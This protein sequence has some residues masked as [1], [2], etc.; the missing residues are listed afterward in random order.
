KNNLYAFMLCLF[1]IRP[2]KV[3]IPFLK[4]PVREMFFLHFLFVD[5][6]NKRR[7]SKIVPYVILKKDSFKNNKLKASGYFFDLDGIKNFR[8]EK[9]GN[10]I[11][12][13]ETDILKLSLI[14][15]KKPL[16]IN[17]N[18]FINYEKRKSYYYSLT[19][20]EAKGEIKINGKSLDVSGKVWHDH[21]WANEKYAKD[22]W[23]WFSIQ[24]DNNVE[25]MI[26]EYFFES[27]KKK[28]LSIIYPNGKQKFYENFELRH[29]KKIWESKITCMEYPLKW[30]IK[31][32]E[33][34]DLSCSAFLDNQEVLFGSINYWEG[35]IKVK[36][37]FDNK[38]ING[39]GFMELN[40]PFNIKRFFDMKE[41]YSEVERYI[42]KLGLLNL[43]LKKQ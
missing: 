33:N 9:A 10:N 8:I 19:D 2:D 36:G 11:Y 22:K 20:L 28:L 17:G 32:K 3:K 21:Q 4:I 31:L 34:I 25:L 13:I 12:E 16:L 41:L 15:K 7:V 40:Y 14:S 1:R 5:I 24:L 18:G 43:W 6:K 23:S 29:G 26:F 27:N 30:R 39:T 42:N 37:F 35:P 38:I